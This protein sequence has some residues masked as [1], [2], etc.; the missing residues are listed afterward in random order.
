MKRAIEAT[1]KEFESSCGRTPEYLAWH[2]LFKK[3]LTIFILNQGGKD[4]QIGKPNHFDLSGFFTAHDGQI[5]YVSVSDLRGFKD[6]M[7]LRAAKSYKDYSGGRN[8]D[9][10]LTHGEE[11]FA[12]GFKHFVFHQ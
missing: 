10:P 8:N 9:I 7:L 2:R 6:S 3:E 1:Q 5:W 12:D 11:E 4:V